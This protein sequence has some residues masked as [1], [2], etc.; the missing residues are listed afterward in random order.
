VIAVFCNLYKNT[1]FKIT[2]LIV[3][4]VSLLFGVIGEY[5]HLATSGSQEMLFGMFT[6]AGT[7][8]IV[9]GIIAILRSKFMSKEKLRQE[10][11]NI[12]DERNIQIYRASYTIANTACTVLFAVMGFLF[13]GLGYQVPGLISIGAL[14]VQ[15]IVF[16]ISYFYYRKKM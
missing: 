7:A 5:H 6:G 8:W 13:V 16:L 11:I 3:G 9:V 12:K 10:E 15:V 14:W 2:L 1:K 4:V